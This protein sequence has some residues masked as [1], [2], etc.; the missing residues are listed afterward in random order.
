MIPGVR[1]KLS[2]LG[3]RSAAKRAADYEKLAEVI[4]PG[5]ASSSAFS[6]I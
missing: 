3:Q 2:N 4:A 1:R 5:G 6:T